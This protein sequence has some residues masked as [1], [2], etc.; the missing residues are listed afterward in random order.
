MPDPNNIILKD[1]EV[2]CFCIPK[3]ANT[4][5][6]RAFMQMLGKKGN[7]HGPGKFETISKWTAG[8]KYP[9][10]FKFAFVRNPYA[11]LVSCYQNKIKGKKF[12]YPFARFG[13]T[14]DTTFSDFVQTIERYPDFLSDQHFRSQYYELVVL[15]DVKTP[16][17]VPDFIGKVETIGPDW[18]Y[19]VEKI[20]NISGR[21]LPPLPRENPDKDK[22]PWQSYYDDH[23]RAL[24]Q[25]R[26]IMDFE[27]FK[28]AY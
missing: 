3:C 19:V 9:H 1:M 27:V 24:V 22:R 28:Y 21:K 8:Y 7:P 5:I 11:R 10:F 17:L 23:T 2:I 15:D 6:K 20:Y 4:S 18:D 14:P 12:H 25:R 26:Y 13:F 16:W